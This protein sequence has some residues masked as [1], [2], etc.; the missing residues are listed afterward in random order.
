MHTYACSCASYLRKMS[1]PIEPTDKTFESLNAPTVAVFGF[2]GYSN[3]RII[4][5]DSANSYLCLGIIATVALVFFL[6]MLFFV[7]KRIKFSIAVIKES[8]R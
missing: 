5:A 6:I 8:S 4:N 7:R 1:M 3:N 2:V